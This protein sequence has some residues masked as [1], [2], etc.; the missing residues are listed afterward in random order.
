MGKLLETPA[1]EVKTRSQ[2]RRKELDDKEREQVEFLNKC[3]NLAQSVIPGLAEVDTD[4]PLE[5]SYQLFK[6]MVSALQT[7]M[8]NTREEKKE[9]TA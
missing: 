8:Q 7:Q 6:S 3:R 2:N 4:K 1:I 5:K 9:E